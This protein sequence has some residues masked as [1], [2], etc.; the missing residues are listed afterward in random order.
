MRILFL[1]VS[2]GLAAQTPM[3]LAEAQALQ[4]VCRMAGVPLIINGAI[5]AAG[6]LAFALKK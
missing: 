4:A 1:A 5:L 6:L 2:L 3:T